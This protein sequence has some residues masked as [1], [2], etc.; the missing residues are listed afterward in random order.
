MKSSYLILGLSFAQL[1]IFSTYSVILTLCRLLQLD[2]H[3]NIVDVFISQ[4]I[5]TKPGN[6]QIELRLEEFYISTLRNWSNIEKSVLGLHLVGNIF[7]GAVEVRCKPFTKCTL[8]FNCCGCDKKTFVKNSPI[9]IKGSF[10][11]YELT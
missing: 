7:L 8:T 3:G 11:H 1:F 9:A 5:L 2:D 4:Y 6:F 10:T